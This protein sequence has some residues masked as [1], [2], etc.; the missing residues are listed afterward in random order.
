MKLEVHLGSSTTESTIRVR[1]GLIATTPHQMKIQLDHISL[2]EMPERR[3]WFLT[4]GSRTAMIPSF[5]QSSVSQLRCPSRTLAKKLQC[6]LDV[7]VCDCHPAVD[8]MNC[9]CKD[10]QQGERLLQEHGIEKD[11]K[12]GLRMDDYNDLIESIDSATQTLRIELA[13]FEVTK[14]VDGSECEM[15]SLSVS[16]CHSCKEGAQLQ[17]Q[18]HSSHGEVT[19]L[20]DCGR[21]LMEPIACS[22]TSSISNKSV[23]INQQ[24]INETCRLTCPRS[25][26]LTRITATL[27]EPTSHWSSGFVKAI[28]A[29]PRDV[30]KVLDL[31]LIG[32]D[33]KLYFAVIL[34]SV[35]VVTALALLAGVCRRC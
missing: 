17:Y 13:N 20:L 19:G 23:H 34:G 30:E 27:D 32:S 2:P 1:P 4:D 35:L 33:E 12:E 15:K 22:S 24:R 6:S 14:V 21:V 25:S 3:R 28:Q 31:H 18:C 5:L 11:K 26:S 8:L 16:G 9:A 29:I 10:G 7:D